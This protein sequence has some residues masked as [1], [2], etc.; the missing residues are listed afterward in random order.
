[1]L[2]ID[3]RHYK[4]EILADYIRN[5]RGVQKEIQYTTLPRFEDKKVNRPSESDVKPK[6][7]QRVLNVMLKSVG[8]SQQGLRDVNTYLAFLVPKIHELESKMAPISVEAMAASKVHSSS[9]VKQQRIEYFNKRI[10]TYYD[11]L[12]EFKSLNLT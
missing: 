12:E 11:L 5:Q 4:C 7:K 3:F 8:P 10:G 9:I 1:M 2:P 6:K